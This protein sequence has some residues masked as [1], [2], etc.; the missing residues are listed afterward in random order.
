MNE[1]FLSLIPGTGMILKQDVWGTID[2]QLHENTPELGDG[3]RDLVRNLTPIRT[4]ALV[5][6][7][8]YE[9]YTQP[10]DSD[11]LWVYA[12][13]VAQEA[14][15]NR[16]YVQYQEGGPLGVH[17]YTNDPHEMFFQ[18]AQGDGLVL[19]TG[20]ALLHIQEALVMVEAG[21]GVPFGS[22]I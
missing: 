2:E 17:T 22:A 12:E 1:A 19:T 4:G 9:A 21:A 8:S 15:W 14:Y 20:W 6:D 10:G 7:I 5:M 16:I 11:L 13:D 3:L 18:T